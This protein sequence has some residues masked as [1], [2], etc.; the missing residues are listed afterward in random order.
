M[1]EFLKLQTIRR[2]IYAL[3][4]NVPFSTSELIELIEKAITQTPSAFNL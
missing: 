1:S 2:S 4:K 3:G